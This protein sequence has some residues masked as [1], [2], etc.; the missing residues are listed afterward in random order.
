MTAAQD[1]DKLAQLVRK[2]DPQATLR[3]SWELKGGVSAQVTALEVEQLDGQ[4]KRMV[5]RRYGARDLAQNPH[6]AAA[7]FKLLHI[8]QAAGIAA[9]AP[10]YLGRAGDIFATPYTVIAYV[11]GAPDFS[12]SDVAGC[13]SQMAAH[14]AAIH[15]VDGSRPALSFLP[16]QEEIC[17]TTLARRPA[18]LDDALSEGAI[19]D[20]L[21]AAW[22]LP[23]RNKPALLHGDYWPGNILWQDGRLMAVVD[24]EDAARGDPLA[25]LANSRL[26]VL[27]A[28][29][30][31]AM[32]LFTHYY[33]A[34]TAL[35]AS[36]LPYWDLYAALR[37]ASKLSTWGLDDAAE[38]AMREEHRLFVTQA[39][40]A[41]S[42]RTV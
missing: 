8:A 40:D 33:R 4:I 13:V 5:V 16:A 41:L 12:P 35:D 15:R 38:T 28:W 9:P 26:E 2:L 11:E 22:P 31:K 36:A 19:R 42:D 7:E 37:P 1:D 30:I 24:W 23:C 20:A 32:R 27:W 18:Q 21:A 29:G 39:F 14:L 10:Y 6:V 17:A 25:D 34:T 3:R